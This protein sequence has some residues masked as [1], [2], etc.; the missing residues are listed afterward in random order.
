MS[1][2]KEKKE[3]PYYYEWGR[4]VY[5]DRREQEEHEQREYDK[6]KEEERKEKER[7]DPWR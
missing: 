6:R 3:G 5:Y 1:Y 4:K 2:G 7:T